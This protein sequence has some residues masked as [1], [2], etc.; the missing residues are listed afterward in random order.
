MVLGPW[1]L[2]YGPVLSNVMFFIN[3]EE[4]VT[5]LEYHPT[6]R[7]RSGTPLLAGAYGPRL[8][9]LLTVG[10]TLRHRKVQLPVLLDRSWRTSTS[11]HALVGNEDTILLPAQSCD[12]LI[13]TLGPVL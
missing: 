10:E 11:I 1:H 13:K 9:Q 5:P 2:F 12:C 7:Q 3:V 8:V 4:V 6:Q